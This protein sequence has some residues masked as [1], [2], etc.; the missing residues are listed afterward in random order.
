M[1][2]LAVGVTFGDGIAAGPAGAVVL[3]LLSLTISLA[4][5]AIGAW[6]ALR[7]GNGEAVQGTFPLLRRAVPLVD[8][9]AA[10]PD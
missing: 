5:G 3:V 1:T 2:F 10:E 6:V 4:F 7:A 9:P 8:E